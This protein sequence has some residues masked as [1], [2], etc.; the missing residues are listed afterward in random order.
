MDTKKCDPFPLLNI[1]KH[2]AINVSEYRYNFEGFC[3]NSHTQYLY[4]EGKKS[5]LLVPMQASLET[6]SFSSHSLSVKSIKLEI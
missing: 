6:L 4:I 2:K 1:F 3:E 5:H